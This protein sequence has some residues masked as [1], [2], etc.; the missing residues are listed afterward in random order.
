MR[1]LEIDTKGLEDDGAIVEATDHPA[2][3][4]YVGDFAPYQLT[5]KGRQMLV[6]GGFPIDA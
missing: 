3:G 6:G 1:G 4:R 2:H 5:H